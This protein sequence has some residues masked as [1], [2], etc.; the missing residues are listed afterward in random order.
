MLVF[1]LHA[2]STFSTDKIPRYSANVYFFLSKDKSVPLS[3]CHMST[4]FWKVFPDLS[5]ATDGRI[6]RS[7][8]LSEDENPREYDFPT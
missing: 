1:S 3:A 2:P 6:A 8:L 4:R 7:F 5:R